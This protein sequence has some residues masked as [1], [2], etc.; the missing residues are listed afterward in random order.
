MIIEVLYNF[1]SICASSVTKLIIR[2][3]DIL[4]DA[5]LRQIVADKIFCVVSRPIDLHDFFLNYY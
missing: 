1:C 4:F 5:K 3:G 2:F